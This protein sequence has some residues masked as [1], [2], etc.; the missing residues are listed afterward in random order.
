MNWL[1]DSFTPAATKFFAKP[2][3]AA[4]SASM[5][6]II[7]YI[8]TG[9]VIF[10]YGVF[11]SFI[12]ALPDLGA[13]S[14]YSFGIINLIVTFVV[15]NQCM[16]KLNHPQ[17][18]INAG[19][20][21]MGVLMM[22]AAPFGESADSLS[23]FMGNI[24]P[25][26]MIA[27]ILMGIF[28]A[29]VFHMFAKLEFLKDSS[30][31]DFVVT[32][33]NTVLPNLIVLGITMI[34]TRYLKINIYQLVLDCFNPVAKIG[35]TLPGFV[36]LSLITSFFYTLGISTWLWDAILNPIFMIAI[37]ENVANAAAGLPPVNIVTHEAWYTLAFITMGGTCATLG[38]NLLMCFSKS[39]QVKMLGRV[40][41]APSIF[42]INEPVMFGAPVVFN[43]VLMIPA[44]INA[45]VGPVYIWILM[46]A[47]LLNIP[48]TIIQ[49]GQIP[50]PISSVMVTQDLRA[51]LWWIILLV[52]YTAIWFPFFK[53][54][55]K[56]KL[57]EEAE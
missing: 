1:S 33:I 14:S 56:N 4:I 31:P 5:Q 35:Q 2:W 23:A 19:L 17:Y 18:T 48:S 9:S 15:A 6:K 34:V 37:T 30:V 24:G 49:I 50:A 8:L 43:P 40:F 20:T 55:E 13:I 16:E 42:N 10:F 54:Y 53:V 27:G 7:P 3:I 45:I 26:G 29:F 25:S 47:H 57:A 28:T 22:V 51:V 46:K 21:A 12:P 11:R 44:W 39:K 38:L 52:I 41:L 32:W 36:I